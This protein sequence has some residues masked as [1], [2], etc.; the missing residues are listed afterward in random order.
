MFLCCTFGYMDLLI[1]VKWFKVWDE[2][3]YVESVPSIINTMID[4]FMNP[5]HV[6][7]GV[8]QND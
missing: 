4:F 7:D 8:L 1:L 2:D 6:K 5:S 3:P